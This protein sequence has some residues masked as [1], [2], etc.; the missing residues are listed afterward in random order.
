[1]NPGHI[2]Y[3]VDRNARKFPTKEAISDHRGRW[4]Y[5][6]LRQEVLGIVG[7]LCGLGV[8][9]KDRVATLMTNRG[10]LIVS[11]LALFRMGAILVPLNTRLADPEWEY[12]LRDSGARWIITESMFEGR[13]ARIRERLPQIEEVISVGAQEKGVIGWEEILTAP[14]M[15]EPPQE[16][17][18]EDEL[19]ILYTSGTTGK[20]KGAVITHQNFL[21][22]AINGQITGGF[23]GDDVVYYGLPLF[24]AAAMGGCFATMLLGGKVVLRPRFDPVELLELVESERITRVPA[25][26]PMLLAIL[27]APGLEKKDLSSLRAFNTGAT[28]IPQSLKER[29]HERFPWVEITDSYGL[30]EATSYCTV[31]AGKEFL[32]KKACVGR[33]HAYVEIRVVDERDRDLPPGQVG[34][35]LVRGPNVMKGYWMRPEETEEAL[36]GGWLHTGDLGRMDEEGYLYVVDRKKDM[37]ITGGE[38]VYPREVEEVLNSHPSVMEAAVVG[39]P[40]EK[41]GERVVAFVIPRPGIAPDP[42]ELDLHCR[43]HLASYKCPK[44]YRVV[45]DLP[46]TSTG[47]ILKRVLRERWETSGPR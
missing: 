28:T 36:R 32:A 27:E 8:K 20:P 7:G 21:W 41:W 33:P 23:K 1:M 10:E 11:Y 46:R 4:S 43:D 37:I 47:K 44:E 39:V 26:P 42:K 35:I 14:P 30:T 38:N 31:L 22:N 17:G 2:G 12:I 16:P 6:R 3:L 9:R 40:D 34:E 24:H 15:E 5:A 45:E 13:I 19:Y 18:I 29:L 25:V